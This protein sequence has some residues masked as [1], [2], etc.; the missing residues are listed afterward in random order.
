MSDSAVS[1]C[2]GSFT[3]NSGYFIS[4]NHPGDYPA[5]SLC[6]WDI[7]VSVGETIT[8][9]FSAF[10]LE[11]TSSTCA[12]DYVQVSLVRSKERFSLRQSPHTI[13]FIVKRLVCLLF[14]K[15]TMTC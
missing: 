4:P 10:E 15:N 7:T 8:L 11:S 3:S 14:D 6:Y 12:F 13:L 5:S 9:S 1:G 2:G